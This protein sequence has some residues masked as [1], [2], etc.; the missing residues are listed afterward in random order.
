MDILGVRS[1]YYV[2]SKDTSKDGLSEK[3]PMSFET[4]KEKYYKSRDKI[5]FK[6]GDK[7][8]GSLIQKLYI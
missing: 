3:D 6:S 8:Y 5:L 1:T 2:S 7:F 4:A